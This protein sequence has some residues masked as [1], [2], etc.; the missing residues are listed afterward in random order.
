[1]INSWLNGRR[2]LRTI[3]IT[4]L[5]AGGTAW[6]QVLTLTE[7]H[8]N[9]YIIFYISSI[10][11]VTG[12]MKFD[13]FEFQLSS[14]SYPVEVYAQFEV[15]INSPSVG[16]TYDDL[17]WRE[18]TDTFSLE[19]PIRIRNT[20]TDVDTRPLIYSGGILAGQEVDVTTDTTISIIDDPSFNVDDFL[21]VII[22]TGRLPDGTYRYIL[23]F[24]GPD[25]SVELDKSFIASRPFA[26]QLISPGGILEDTLYTAITTTVPIFQWESDPCAICSY[27]IRVAEFI[28][29]RHMS[30]EEALEDRTV[31]PLDQEQDFYEVGKGITSFQYPRTGAMDLWQGRIY[32]W[33]IQKVIPTTAGE[34]P[35]NSFIYTFKIAG[36]TPTYFL[37]DDNYPNP[38]APNPF[39]PGTEISFSIVSETD[40][41]LVVIDIFGRQVA[42]LA[43]GLYGPGRYNVRWE[44]RNSD[45]K[46]VA[47]G[48]YLYRLSAQNSSQTK[49]LVLLK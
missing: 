14:E 47:S 30:T 34:E 26:L 31:L 35:I 3:V 7:D 29:G 44:G 23:R 24:T 21:S 17:F 22:Q 43:S 40:I 36:Q 6:G 5:M 20:D 27:K 45:G 38:F 4:A 12:A 41:S 46:R 1:M 8:F 48:I 19:G 28:P 9:D 13:W 49:K 39:N 15:R 32:A 25:N 18:V 11:L 33:Q 16:L 2:V 10:D 42:V 37:L